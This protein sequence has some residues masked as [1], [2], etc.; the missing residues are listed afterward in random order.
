[1]PLSKLAEAMGYGFHQTF[2]SLVPLFEPGMRIQAM[3]S[4]SAI[5][6][7]E[8]LGLEMIQSGDNATLAIDAEVWQLADL[9]R[10][11]PAV[12]AILE[13]GANADALEALRGDPAASTFVAEFDAL[14]A[15]HPSRSIGWEMVLPTWRERPET[16]LALV[17][18][19]LA[20]ARAATRRS[21]RTERR[22]PQRGDERVLAKLRPEKGTE[23][24]DLLAS[25]DGYIRI[26]EGRAYWQ[27]V[28]MGESRGVA[29]RHGERLVAAGALDRGED[30]FLFEPHEIEADSAP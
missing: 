16:A 27:M 2:T 26:R 5:E 18:A 12:R 4:Q 13:R 29:L 8:L 7:A 10:R 6:D 15:R 1:M 14:I 25:L 3:L 21:R 28:L 17:A 30:V 23:L 22:P 9:A 20:S 19:Q 11:T 24:K